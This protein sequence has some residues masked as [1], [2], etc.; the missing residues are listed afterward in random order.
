MSIW[1]M[2]DKKKTKETDVVK[3]QLNRHHTLQRFPPSLPTSCPPGEEAGMLRSTLMHRSFLLRTLA[4]ERRH[5]YFSVVKKRGQ[6]S[7]RP[8]VVRIGDV[9]ASVA[10]PKSPEL[11]PRGFYDHVSQ[12]QR[13][14]RWG[15]FS[16]S[17]CSWSWC[18]WMLSHCC[19]DR[20][21]GSIRRKE[22]GG[23]S[24]HA[25]PASWAV[26]WWLMAAQLLR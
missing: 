14:L 8:K 19:T 9:E 15:T 22:E 18:S 20:S 21:G 10:P 6:D 7:A 4:R 23:R 1:S 25:L 24:C 16:W 17:W 26:D 3:N 5:A 2:Q 13:S 11:V 12:S